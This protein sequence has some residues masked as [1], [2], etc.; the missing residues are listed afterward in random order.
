MQL[1]KI[2]KTISVKQIVESIIQT[3][4]K[5]NATNNNAIKLCALNFY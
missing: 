2:K 1:N 3:L 4:T 5:S